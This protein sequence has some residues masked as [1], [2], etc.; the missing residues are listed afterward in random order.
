MR[1][2]VLFALVWCL[3]FAVDGS[4]PEKSTTASATPAAERGE[5]LADGVI[6]INKE[7]ETT[8][9]ILRPTPITVSKVKDAIEVA[10]NEVAESD[11]PGKATYVNTLTQIASTGHIPESVRFCFTPITSTYSK[12]QNAEGRH[13]AISLNYTM[14]LQSEHGIRLI[15]LLKIVEV[16]QVIK[17]LNQ[18]VPIQPPAKKPASK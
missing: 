14:E 17:P 6:R 8:Y 3:T 7:V 1:T 13:L 4:E 18:Q 15:G 10:A 11:I 9:G 2:A 12:D 16:F 5:S